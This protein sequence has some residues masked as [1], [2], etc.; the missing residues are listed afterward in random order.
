MTDLP[1]TAPFAGPPPLSSLG[2]TAPDRALFL[3]VALAI[4]AIRALMTAS[5]HYVVGH[6]ELVQRMGLE[7]PPRP[8]WFLAV[9]EIPVWFGWLLLVPLILRCADHFPVSGP[10]RLFH[11][12]LHLFVFFPPAAL[13]SSLMIAVGRWPL[14]GVEPGGLLQHCGAYLMVG[15]SAHTS[16]YS[17]VL[18]G[19]HALCRA[20]DLHRRELEEARVEGLLARARLQALQSQMHPHFLFNALNGISGLIGRDDRLARRMVGELGGLLRAT[21]A[22]EDEEVPLY[23]ELALLDRYVALESARFGDRF[24][25][26]RRVPDEAAELLVP[27]FVLQPLVE[28]AV[29]HGVERRRAPVEVRLSA[30]VEGGSL[31]LSVADDGPGLAPG[32]QEGVGLGNLRERLRVLY[33]ADQSLRAR[34]AGRGTEVTVVL[35]VRESTAAP[36]SEAAAG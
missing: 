35:P 27:R 6:F 19:H 4:A 28:N 17:L 15:M 34:A 10:R 26:S 5:V 7:T 3:R 8:F 1:R 18:L 23:A 29:K 11:L 21:I 2:L 33:G 36:I 20:R 24:R 32:A 9:L 25:F 12:A 16:S 31:V 13:A 14:L 22:D 30:R